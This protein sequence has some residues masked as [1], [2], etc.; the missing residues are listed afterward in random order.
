MADTDPN[1]VHLQTAMPPTAVTPEQGNAAVTG[2]LQARD[3]RFPGGASV[4]VPPGALD[5]WTAAKSAG[6]I[7]PVVNIGT[8]LSAGLGGPANSV[9]ERFNRLFCNA[10]KKKS[11][12]NGTFWQALDSAASFNAVAGSPAPWVFTTTAGAWAVFRWFC[13]R[14]AQLSAAQTAGSAIFTSPVPFTDAD[15]HYRQDS[16][17]GTFDLYVDGVMTA[18]LTCLN[19]TASETN[20][21]Q[22]TGLNYTTHT[23]ELRST[24]AATT[25][26]VQ[27]VFT[28]S[29]PNGRLAPGI[30]EWTIGGAGAL[31]TSVTDQIQGQGTATWDGWHAMIQGLGAALVLL[32]FS[33]NEANTTATIPGIQQAFADFAQYVQLQGCS[34]VY[35]GMPSYYL[36]GT[37][38]KVTFGQIPYYNSFFASLA[39]ASGMA[40]MMC[41]PLLGKT[42]SA[43][44]VASSI[45]HLNTA[46]H[47]LIAQ[48][49][50]AWLA[51]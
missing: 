37:T 3:F 19:A 44:E 16:T 12:D 49:L 46:G 29:Q 42:P 30:Q 8:S 26:L 15:V 6:G 35:L 21:Y 1:A 4:E 39:I 7:I 25:M 43:Y 10:L 20:V 14:D 31:L 11:G 18:H 47:A 22:L 27:G 45:P 40:T 32:E 9:A 36:S 50:I 13:G 2:Y 41:Q 24:Q 38:S 48:A 5:A 17:G 28:Y 34:A 23:I 33:T 51:S